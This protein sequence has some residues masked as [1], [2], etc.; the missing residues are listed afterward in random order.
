MQWGLAGVV[1]RIERRAAGNQSLGRCSVPVEGGGVQRGLTIE[2]CDA[3]GE[4]LS[5]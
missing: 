4:L 5:W 3:E 1:F 2:N